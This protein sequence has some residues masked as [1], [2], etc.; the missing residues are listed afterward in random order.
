MQGHVHV[1]QTEFLP[2]LEPQL[3]YALHEGEENSD[4]ERGGAQESHYRHSMQ[5]HFRRHEY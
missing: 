5:I 4:E 2:R 3:Y 1:P